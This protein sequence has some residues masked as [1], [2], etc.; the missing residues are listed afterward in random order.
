M[1][2]QACVFYGAAQVSK[3][4]DEL[5][6]R[7]PCLGNRKLV[8]VLG[9]EHGLTV[10]RKRLR[11]LREL[12]GQQTLYRMPRTSLGNK[13]HRIYPYLMRKQRTSDLNLLAFLNLL[14]INSD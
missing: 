12:M 13:E 9:R 6:L 2:G 1:G 8:V 10:N 7:D 11:R 4:V 5:Y 3:D 14:D